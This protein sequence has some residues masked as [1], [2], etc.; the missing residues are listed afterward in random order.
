M[1]KTKLHA[2]LALFL[3]LTSCNESAK[4]DNT[5]TMVKSETVAT[6]MS[7]VRAAIEKIENDWAAALNKKDINA[8]IALY[9]DDA[10]SM[11]NDGP[12]LKGKAA[13]REQ[14]EKDFA[15]PPRYASISFQTQ[16]IYGTADEVTEVGTSTE[17]DAAGN[18]TRTGKYIAV[19][20]KQDGTYV[21]VREIYNRDSK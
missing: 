17:K 14:Q 1:K 6:D 18:V 15:A 5:S 19:F 3:A 7:Q 4:T 21:C 12:S 20:K 8:L 16:D 10:I 13:I 9:A 2:C 11:Q